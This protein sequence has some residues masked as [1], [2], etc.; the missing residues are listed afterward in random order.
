M[1]IYK[2]LFSVTNIIILKNKTFPALWPLLDSE[3]RFHEKKLLI[4]EKLAIG[5]SIINVIINVIIA[6]LSIHSLKC[7]L[8]VA[9]LR[10]ILK[11]SRNIN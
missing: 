7:A 6:I 3:Y 1:I 10:M 9:K 2:S 11:K 8:K 4:T 5:I